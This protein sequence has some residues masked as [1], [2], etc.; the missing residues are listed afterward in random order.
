M[1]DAAVKDNGSG[2]NGTLVKVENL[3]KFFPIRRGIFS[4]VAGTIG[5]ES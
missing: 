4:R 1:N 2:P 5:I 3:K